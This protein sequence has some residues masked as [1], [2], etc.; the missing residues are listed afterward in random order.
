MINKK[1][2]LFIMKKIFTIIA[3]F[4][5]IVSINAQY[6]Y[7]DFDANQ[8]DVV[9]DWP[10]ATTDFINVPAGSTDIK[11]YS[12]TEKIVLDAP[13]SENQVYNSDF[14]GGVYFIYSLNNDGFVHCSK[15]LKK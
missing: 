13:S 4:I 8:N 5:G 1:S 2:K 3:L 6:V 10:N 7:I 14:S 9:L 15:F 12:I 11:N